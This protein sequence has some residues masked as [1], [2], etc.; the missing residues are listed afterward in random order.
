M[1]GEIRSLWMPRYRVIIKEGIYHIIQRAPGR[2]IIFCEDSDYLYFLHLLKKLYEEFGLN[3]LCFSLL[4]NHFHLLIKL[5]EPN[6]TQLMRKLLTSYAMY[7][8]TKYQRKGHVFY[9]RYRAS[10]CNDEKYLITL[11]L[12]IHL[13]PFNAKL[14]KFPQDYKWCSLP[15]YIKEK[16]SSFVRSNYILSLLS[17]DIKKAKE[18]YRDLLKEASK[19]K[20]K[21]VIEDKKAPFKFALE[22]VKFLS[23]LKLSCKNRSVLEDIEEKIAFLKSKKLLKKPQDKEALV[24][25]IQQ[26]ESRGFTKREIGEMVGM[27]PTTLYR[28]QNAIKKDSP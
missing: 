16:K 10:F 11:S 24:Y 15:F 14:C 8:N 1:E 7:F 20:A 27:N 4:P 9:G 18:I 25:L 19:I 12:Y 28:V 6:L 2:E 23:S 22:I 13:N 3:L 26:L 21:D 17:S 5:K